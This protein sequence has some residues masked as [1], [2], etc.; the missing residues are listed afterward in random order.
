MPSSQY[1]Y[2]LNAL[3]SPPFLISEIEIINM[4][5]LIDLFLIEFN[6]FGDSE[7]ID[8]VSELLP[9]DILA[10][11]LGPEYDKEGSAK[12]YW[13]LAIY[14]RNEIAKRNMEGDDQWV[15]KA[16]NAINRSKI[17]FEKHELRM[18]QLERE[19]RVARSGEGTKSNDKRYGPLNMLKQAACDLY[20]PAIAELQ[21]Q[22]QIDKKRSR[23]NR[24]TYKNIAKIIYPKITDLNRDRDGQKIIG[25][26]GDPVGS[27]AKIFQEAAWK[28][29]L[30]S[31]RGR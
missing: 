19:I 30:K 29:N 23:D 16:I 26:N 5:P 20:E 27:L 1:E 2:L 7:E 28:G 4:L 9:T 24:T 22:R 21:L 12:W 15:N 17:Y 8:E 11:Q 13:V 10:N 31:V 6:I 14:L 18:R 25:R 3:D